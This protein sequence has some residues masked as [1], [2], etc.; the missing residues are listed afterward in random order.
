[1]Q[2]LHLY[3]VLIVNACLFSQNQ[4][5][6]VK[7]PASP[8][9]CHQKEP[10]AIILQQEPSYAET[11]DQCTESVGAEDPVENI[12][13]LPAKEEDKLLASVEAQQVWSD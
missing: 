13:A 6:T 4:A 12:G 3:H 1:M 8:T 11:P 7:D 9:T 10:S 5:S 2:E